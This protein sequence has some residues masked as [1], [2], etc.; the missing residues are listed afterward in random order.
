MLQSEKSKYR[1][2]DIVHPA[3]I[4]LENVPPRVGILLSE[5]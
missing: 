3:N 5:R 4:D 2:C 1:P